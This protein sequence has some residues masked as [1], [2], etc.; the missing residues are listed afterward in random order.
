M[1]NKKQ[2]RRKAIAK[3]NELNRTRKVTLEEAKRIVL[4]DE[5]D[6]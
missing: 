3:Q 4:K 6:E 5:S 1:M 2:L